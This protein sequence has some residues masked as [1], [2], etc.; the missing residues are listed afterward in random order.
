MAS[1]YEVVNVGL[2]GTEHVP[3]FVAEDPR[4]PGGVIRLGGRDWLVHFDLTP[5]GRRALREFSGS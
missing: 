5:R 2:S 1:S 4:E 3:P